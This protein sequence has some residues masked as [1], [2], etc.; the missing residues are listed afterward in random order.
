[1]TPENQD[2]RESEDTNENISTKELINDSGESSEID[3]TSKQ[4][5]ET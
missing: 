4:P 2:I 3:N 1:M 5:G